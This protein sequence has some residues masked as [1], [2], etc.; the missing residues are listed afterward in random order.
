MQD[1]VLLLLLE[2]S[3]FPLNCRQAR[4]VEWCVLIL[5][6]CTPLRWGISSE[7]RHCASTW[8]RQHNAN[9]RVLSNYACITRMCR[10]RAHTT[11]G[12]NN[13]RQ[14]SHLCSHLSDNNS[15]AVVLIGAHLLK[16]SRALKFSLF[17]ACVC[18]LQSGGAGV[19]RALVAGNSPF[20][21]ISVTLAKAH[22]FR[23]HSSNFL[24]HCVPSKTSSKRAHRRWIFFSTRLG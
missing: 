1:S 16:I 21:L 9:K 8:L 23:R 7:E 12:A 22:G 11:H 5:G 18:R 14:L 24:G 4:R 19:C 17:R 15:E 2:K 20:S 13:E 3:C 6:L 10:A